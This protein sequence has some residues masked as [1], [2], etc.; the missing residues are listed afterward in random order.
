[1]RYLAMSWRSQTGALPRDVL[2]KLATPAVWRSQTGALPRDVLA[3]FGRAAVWRSPNRCVA[4]RRFGE[5]R[6]AC[7]LAKP[8][9]VR[10]WHPR[11]SDYE[12]R[13]LTN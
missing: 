9:C 3:K 6:Y 1:M 10:A 11:P 5:A 4:A 13:A 7:S 2:A 8:N 12:S